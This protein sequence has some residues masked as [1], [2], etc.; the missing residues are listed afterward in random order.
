MAQIDVLD[1]KDI[2]PIPYDFT[3][4][5][6]TSVEVAGRFTF[7]GEYERVDSSTLKITKLPYGLTHKKLVVG[8]EKTPSILDKLVEGNDITDY[9]DNSSDVFDITVKFKRGTLNHYRMKR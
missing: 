4:T 1:G 8:T 9:E 6:N 7:T 2:N 5:D 3:P